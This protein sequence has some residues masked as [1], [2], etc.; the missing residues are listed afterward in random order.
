MNKEDNNEDEL[1]K[2]NIKEENEFKKLKLNLE[3]GAIF[4]DKMSNN[5][6]PELEAMFLDS[7]M[8]F[9]K[10]YQN[11]KQIS[12]YKKMGE[13]EFKSQFTLS[14]IEITIELNRILDLMNQNGLDLS[15]L[16]DYDDEDRLIYS[17]I[18]EELFLHEI[19]DINVPGMISNFVYEEFHPNH[20]YDLKRETEDF[21]KMFFD[22]K[23]DFYD[24]YHS[25]DASNHAGLNNF[26]SLFHEF[27]MTFFHFQEI[28]F[29]EKNAIV[30]FKIDFW[31]KNDG[32]DSK[33]SYSGDG[34]MTF[35]YE[36][37]YWYLR[38]VTL[39]IKV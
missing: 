34:S 19:N 5:L 7:V 31:A 24:N 11:V 10:V 27:Q 23:D 15:V 33:I 17:F 3:Y 1:P 12:V 35:E 21:L 28:A 13:P 6:P 26:R 18:T 4:P 29:D 20:G 37:G 2:L 32:K 22:T 39:P 16:S 36:Y 14:D 30:R 38:E 8:N 25:K 9:E